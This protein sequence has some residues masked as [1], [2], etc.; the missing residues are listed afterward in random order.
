MPSRF[1]QV[2]L[3]RDRARPRQMPAPTDAAVETRLRELLGPAVFAVGDAARALGLR[4]RQL[5]LPV[6][7]SLVTALIWRQVPSVSELVRLV[8]REDVLGVPAQ[9]VTQQAVSQRLRDL[10]ADLFGDILAQLLPVLADRAAARDRPVPAP[11]TMVAAAYPQVWAVDGTTLETVT[12]QVG[13]RRPEK[14]V[15]QPAGT[16]AALL[17]VGTRL[18]VAL[19][20]DDDPAA[21][22]LRFADRIQAALPPHTLLLGDAQFVSYP[23]WDALTDAGHA[24]ICRSRDKVA[25]R[26]VARVLVDQP[27]VRDRIVRVGSTKHPC[28]HPVRLIEVSKNGRTWHRLITTALDPA[29][30]DTAT[31][32]D[33]YAQRWRIEDAFLLTKR[34]LGMSYLWAGAFNAI[35]LQ[36]WATWLL[37]AVLVD[38]TDAVAEVLGR[39]LGDLSIEMVYRGLYHY[40]VA[41]RRGA[42]ADPVAYLAAEAEALAIIKRRRPARERARQAHQAWRAELNL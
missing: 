22:D 1:R 31:V 25:I 27:R 18:P 28:R 24:L 21:N 39:P 16:L 35:A 20:L 8:A 11:V 13:L 34:L 2:T 10:P 42:A 41:A 29:V 7:T 3:D 33:L 23:F 37:Y 17:D 38:L 14:A 5:T 4:D 40:T 12:H 15:P 6:M 26:A 32:V 30:L 36:V 19:W 9:R